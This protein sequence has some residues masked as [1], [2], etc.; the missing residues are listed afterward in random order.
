MALSL[1]SGV[2]Q[3]EVMHSHSATCNCPERHNLLVTI[4][5]YKSYQMEASIIRKKSRKRAEPASR[6]ASTEV[7]MFRRQLHHAHMS[8]RKTPKKSLPIVGAPV[9]QGV[10]SVA[11][12]SSDA[13]QRELYSQRVDYLFS[14]HEPSYRPN[15]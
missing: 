10:Q 5:G 8:I 12:T 4:V 13:Q 1:C 7:L 11:S 6:I 14:F 15:A 3:L 2:A 9:H